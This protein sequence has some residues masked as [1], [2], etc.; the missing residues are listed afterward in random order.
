MRE[1][2]LR[3]VSAELVEIRT[4]VES[5]ALN[6][7]HLPRYLTRASL[8]DLA[9][10]VTAAL[11]EIS[12]DRSEFAKT[13]RDKAQARNEMLTRVQQEEAAAELFGDSG[14]HPQ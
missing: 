4:W 9:R 8:G 5:I 7:T 13:R 10:S 12:L 14:G 1:D 3:E 2:W 11:A 6:D